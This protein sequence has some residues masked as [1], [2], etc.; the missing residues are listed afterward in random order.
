MRIAFVGA[1]ESS[2]VA[3]RA[4]VESSTPPVLVLTLSPEAAARHSDF[5]DL[6]DPARAV[7]A[8]VHFTR[9]INEPEAVAALRAAVADLTLVVGWSQFCGEEFRGAT[10][11]GAVG[12]HPAPLPRFRGRAVIPWTIIA[13][14]TTTGSTIFW[15]DDGVDSGPILA[16]EQF[17]VAPNETARSLYEKHKQALCRLLPQALSRV[18][19]GAPGDLQDEASAS[20][21]ARRTP[22]DGLID[23]HEP[24]ETVLRLIRAVGDPYPGAFT[25]EGQ[26]KITI[27]AA[28]PSAAPGRFIGIAGQIQTYTQNGFVVLCGDGAAIEILS[29]RNANARRP[30]MHARLANARHD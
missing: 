2:L 25:F 29:W 10:R 19:A 6:A 13:G 15:L 8:A 24:A 7:G 9:N 23:W 12:Y 22:A 30:K 16:Q 27:D 28:C 14:A 18:A 17:P 5:A 26:E 4:L 1:V 3:F 11:L 21:C 20:Y